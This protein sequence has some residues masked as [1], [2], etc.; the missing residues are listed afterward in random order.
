MEH[1]SSCD[2]YSII[3][4]T[5]IN[6]TT[7]SNTPLTLFHTFGNASSLLCSLLYH[8]VNRK[9]THVSLKHANN[10][11]S[12]LLVNGPLPCVYYSY[13]HVNQ[14]KSTPLFL[15]C[16]NNVRPVCVPANVRPVCVPAT[17]FSE[18]QKKKL[19]HTS[20]SVRQAGRDNMKRSTPHVNLNR[21]DEA[22]LCPVSVGLEETAP[23]G[24]VLPAC[25][26]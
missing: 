13:H 15:R 9:K 1:L 19:F 20:A 12:H 6:D 24:T 25:L 11:I 7:L 21:Q 3:T 5:K 4:W 2:Q 18:G 23:G 10:V 26:E 22:G 14:T 17:S 16:I 8:Y